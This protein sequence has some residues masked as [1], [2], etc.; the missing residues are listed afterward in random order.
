M[1]MLFSNKNKQ[2]MFVGN[3][4]QSLRSA[5][6]LARMDSNTSFIAFITVFL[7]VYCLLF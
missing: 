5:S 7:A 6:S 3:L 1:E 2:N 4:G